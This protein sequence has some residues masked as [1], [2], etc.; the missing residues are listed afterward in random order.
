M[1]LIVMYDLGM[2]LYH[3]TLQ[4]PSLHYH[5]FQRQ[6]NVDYTIGKPKWNNNE[7]CMNEAGPT[8]ALYIFI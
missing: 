5:E 2:K 8:H 6:T 4:L 3:K 1:I 7:I